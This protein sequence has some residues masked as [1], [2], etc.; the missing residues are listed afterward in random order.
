MKT[1]TFFSLA[2]GLFALLLSGCAQKPDFKTFPKIDAHLHLETSDDSFVK[3]AEESNFKFLTLAYDA[4]SRAKIERQLNYSV[5]LH[6]EHPETVFFASSFNMDG[7][8]ETG[9]QEQTIR[10]LKIDFDNGAIALKV[11]KDIGMVFQDS[12]SSFIMMDDVRLDPIWDFIQL[13][14]KTLVN[15]TGEPKNC[16]LPLENMSVRNDS[17][18]YAEHPQYHMYLHPEYPSYEEILAARNR[19]LDKHPGLRYVACHLASMEWSVDEQAKFLDKY[20][21]AA[22][23]MASRIEHFKYQDSDKVR[24]FIIKYQ[25]RLLYGTDLEIIEDIAHQSSAE[26]MRGFIEGTYQNDW[27][28]FTTDNVFTQDD[29]VKE[30]RGLNLPMSVL[31][32][33]YYKNAMRM[34]PGLG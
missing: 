1:I 12:D 20:P 4:S 13:Q 33:I 30:Y 25:D 15:H 8:G 11:W 18:Y 14:N 17:G 21:D 5:K 34:Y 22:M 32:K 19:M 10:Q 26:E 7:F 23:D 31:K 16:W 3:V 9:W 29:K 6:N 27:D 24:S 28:Y 2:V